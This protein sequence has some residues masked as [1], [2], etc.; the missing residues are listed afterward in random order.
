MDPLA[1]VGIGDV[2]SLTDLAT[3]LVA[4][5]V[6]RETRNQQDT[7]HAVVVALAEW[8]GRVRA[9]LD[10][11]LPRVDADQV[12]ADLDV[13]ERESAAYLDSLVATDGGF[14]AEAEPDGDS[15]APHHAYIGALV[16]WF[17]F[18]YVWPYYDVVGALGALIGVAIAADDVLSH[19]LGVPTPL[20]WL[21]GRVLYPALPST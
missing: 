21:W 8:T 10:D 7:G 9:R 6:L 15:G 16:M 17:A 3:L 20:D 5:V 19:A 12:R 13:P 1:F 18:G 11:D 2:G 14:P 4:L